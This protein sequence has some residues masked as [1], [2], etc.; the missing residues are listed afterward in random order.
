MIIKAMYLPKERKA[1]IKGFVCSKNVGSI[2]I[3]VVDPDMDNKL[4][5]TEIKDIQYAQLSINSPLNN[6][7]FLKCLE[8][9]KKSMDNK[10]WDAL[11]KE[12]VQRFKIGSIIPTANNFDV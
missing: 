5:E 9:A 11:R 3:A 1:L 12:A 2:T 4:V 10:E 8:H 6:V 7:R